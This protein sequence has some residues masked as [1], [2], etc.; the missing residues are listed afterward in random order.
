LFEESTRIPL[1]VAAPG[2][3]A[4]AVSP[5]LV[6]LVDLYPTLVDLCGLKPP[7]GL[8][9]TSFVPLLDHP[10]QP[11]K[12]AAFT[13]VARRSGAMLEQTDSLGA[14]R[15]DASNL[16]RSVRTERYRYTEWTGGGTELY[17]HDVDPCEY[18]NLGDDRGHAA[19]RAELRSLLHAGRKT[20]QR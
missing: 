10:A 3:K 15:L 6:E 1:L 20:A 16:G 5:R 4:G 9:G 14:G 11:W 19:T 17:D 7:A 12:K 13:V 2:K 8:E 18:V